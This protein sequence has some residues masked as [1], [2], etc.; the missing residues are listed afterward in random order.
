M[1]QSPILTDPAQALVVLR[2]ATAAFADAQ[3]DS[4]ERLRLALDHLIEVTDADAGAVAVPGAHGKAPVLIAERFLDDVGPL[5]MTVLQSTLAA[6]GPGASI[7]DPPASA[8]VVASSITSILCTPV[9]R[10]GQTL[11]AVYLDRRDKAPFDEVARSLA[12]CFASML[13]L[14]LELTRHAERTEERAEEARAIAEHLG[15]FW[16]FGAIATHNK[17]FAGCL[18]LAERAAASD[19]MLLILGETGAGKEHIARCVHAESARRDGPFVA[20]NCAAVPETL[21]ESELFGHEK[22]A[23]TGA[24]ATRR[25]KFELADGGTLFL[26][27]IGDMPLAMQPKI[28]RVLEDKRVTR[29]GG[30]GERQVDVRIIVAT[31]K[32]LAHEVEAGNF[33][34]DLY[35]RLNVVTVRIP[36]LRE[37]QEDIPHLARTFLE[38][39]TAR[40]GRKLHWDEG[41]LR[42]LSQHEWPG[43]VRELRNAIEKLCVLV[44][45][46]KITLAEV[47]QHLFKKRAPMPL[48]A[49]RGTGKGASGLRRRVLRHE[50]EL[51]QMRS[52]L[53][54]LRALFSGAGAPA[55]AAAGADGPETGGE[56]AEAGPAEAGSYRA[57]MEE[58]S[59]EII[60]RA[61]QL[62]G[63]ISGAARQLGLSRQNLSVRCKRLGLSRG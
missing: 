56:E 50:R 21:L 55:R 45:G 47:E 29:V 44:E 51:Q 1:V 22:G 19:A 62:S 15:G 42:R 60:R 63:S 23:F 49:G 27:E 30:S 40:A 26:D 41:A 17:S 39:E 38:L 10:R 59:R 7:T 58:A 24:H 35:Y 18:H 46:P 43:N 53:D 8:S 32:E 12:M 25:G 4:D 13:A 3:V 20:I 9:R 5:S 34:E 48:P 2:E 31:H 33:R 16:R 36:P 61:L 28:L 6:G 52:E 11:A 37:R 14:S 57:Q 54:E